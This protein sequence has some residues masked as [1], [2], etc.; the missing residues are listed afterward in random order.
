MAHISRILINNPF[1]QFNLKFARAAFAAGGLPVMKIET[2]NNKNLALLNQF[3][4]KFT[5]RFALQTEN[6]VSTN[7]YLPDN[8]ELL[9]VD[10]ATDISSLSNQ[11]NILYVVNSIDQY[12]ALKGTPIAGIIAKGNEAAG[13]VGELTSFILLQALLKETNVPVWLQGGVGIHTAPGLIGMGAHGVFLDYQCCFFPEYGLS[14]SVKDQLLKLNGT[15]T[16]IVNNTRFYEKPSLPD[17]LRKP[18]SNETTPD[19]CAESLFLAQDIANS[20]F[21]SSEYGDLETF[22]YFLNTSISG[23][24]RQAKFFNP[25]KADNQQLCKEL[26]IKY[27]IVQGPMS[28]VSDVPEFACKVANEG[29]LPFIALGTLTKEQAMPVLNETFEKIGNK[30][31][32][33][34]L[35]G[36]APREI[37]AGQTECLKQIRPKA[38]IIAGGHAWQVRELEQMGV[39]AFVHAPTEPIL[40]NFL[41]EGLKNF[42]FEGMECGGHVGPYSSMVLWERQIIRLL[43]EE[44]LEGINVLFAGGISDAR[45][46]LFI[47]LISAPLAARGANVGVIVGSAYIYTKEIVETGAINAVFQG[48][49]L[50]HTHTQVLNT[51]PGHSVRCLNTPF[52][53]YFIDTKQKLSESGLSP[54]EVGKELEKLNLGR[55]RVATKGIEKVDGKP[56]MLDEENQYNKG[57]FMM[58]QVNALFDNT[59]TIADLHRE[60][61]QGSTELLNQLPE[62]SLLFE[63]NKAVD[64]AI[65][66]MACIFPKA[67]NLEQYWLN[68]LNGTDCVVEVPDERWNKAGYFSEGKR[69]KDQ[70][71]SKWG[72]FIPEITFDPVLFGI[73]PQSVASIDPAQLLSLQVAYDALTDAGY[74]NKE[75][76]RENTA[77]IFGVDGGSELSFCYDLRAYYKKYFG[78]LPDELDKILPQFTEDSFPGILANVIPGRIANRMDFRGKN[79]S[80]DA[81]CATSLTA[82]D[83]ACREL[84]SGSANMVV[85]GAVDIHNDIADYIKFSSVQA[86]TF[87]GRCKSFDEK[88]DGISLGEGVA[89]LIL[90][91]LDDAL[92]DDDRV[93]AVIKSVGASSDGKS[94]GLTAPRKEGQIKA[95]RRAYCESGLSPAQIGM[96]EAHGTGTSVGDIIELSAITE[97]LANS[98]ALPHQAF[99]GSVKT[100]IGHTKCVAGM[101]ALI[102][103]GLSVYHAVKTP[104]INLNKPN[105]YYNENYSPFVF[106]NSIAPW[107][108]ATRIA[109]I[110]ALGFG[111]TNYHCVIQ[112]NKPKPVALT[113]S[114]FWPAELLV[115]RADTDDELKQKLDTVETLCKNTPDIRLRDIS[116]TLFSESDKPVKLSIVAT[117]VTDL[118]EKTRLANAKQADPGIYF[119]KETEGKI[120]FLF[121]GQGSQRINMARDLFAYF[122]KMAEFFNGEE[123]LLDILFPRRTFI[124][125]ELNVQAQ[126]ISNTL[127]AQPLLGIVDYSIASLLSGFGIEPDMLAG[128]SYGEIPALCF[129]GVIE[130]ADLVRIS[131]TRAM[132]IIRAVGDDC[133]AM[134][135]LNCSKEELLKLLSTEEGVYPANHNSNKQW[136]ISGYTD[137]IGK[138]ARKLDSLGISYK[139]LPVTCA[140]HSP[141]VSK[142]ADI[143]KKELD[144]FTLSPAKYTV[145]SNTTTLPYPGTPDEIKEILCRQLVSPVRFVDQ[146]K[147]MY[148]NGARIFIETGPAN[149]LGNLV[150]NII[151]KEVTVL[152]TEE[153]NRNGIEKMLDFL[154]RYISTGRTIDYKGLFNDRKAETIDLNNYLAFKPSKTSWYINGNKAV[155]LFGEL[156]AHAKKPFNKPFVTNRTIDNHA[157]TSN[158]KELRVKEY[159][160]NVNALIK[161]QHSVMMDYLGIGASSIADSALEGEFFTGMPEK[162]PET[163]EQIN[164]T[165]GFPQSNDFSDNGYT[166]VFSLLLETISE[167]TGY[168]QDMLADELN[169]E[170]DLSIDSIKRVEI[171]NTLKQKLSN[172]FSGNNKELHDKLAGS[173]TIGDMKAALEISI[174]VQERVSPVRQSSPEEEFTDIPLKDILF[175]TISAKTGYPPDMLDAE[176]DIEADLSI[177][178]IKRMEIINT[179]K[180]R[181][182]QL[183]YQLSGDFS[184]VLSRH[185]NMAGMLGWLT[186]NCFPANTTSKQEKNKVDAAVEQSQSEKV[187]RYK[188][189]LVPSHTEAILKKPLAEKSVAIIDNGTALPLQLKDELI[190]HKMN[191]DIVHSEAD[192]LTLYNGLIFLD[193]A[194]KHGNT[195]IEGLFRYI[196]KLDKNKIEW[197]YLLSD[198]KGILRQAYNQEIVDALQGFSGFLNSL[199]IEWEASCRTIHLKDAGSVKQAPEILVNEL[200]LADNASEVFYINGTRHTGK[201]TAKKWNTSNKKIA[202]DK[203]D[204]IL[205]LGG[206]QGITA[207]VV[208]NL[209]ETMPA[210]Y[211]LVGSTPFP[212][213]NDFG[214]GSIEKD[215]IRKQLIQKNLFKNP[216]ELEKSVT[217]IYKNNQIL[218]TIQAI[219]TKGSGVEYR[220]VDLSQPGSLTNLI[221]QLYTEYGRIDGVIHA[222]G[223][224]DDKF[225]H[226]KTFDSFTRVYN[227]K[228]LPLR[229]LVQNLRPDTRFCVFFSSIA[230][231]TG[232]QG[233]VDY[234]AANSVLDYAALALKHKLKGRVVSINWGPWKGKGMVS[235]S[236]EKDFRRRGIYSI[237]VNEGAGAFVNELLYGTTEQVIIMAGTNIPEGA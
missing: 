33:V 207:E 2:F 173:K 212:T 165:T 62:N 74:R 143:F 127:N 47:S 120:A 176:M 14:G 21:Y 19:N 215:E 100:Q 75:F 54:S 137:D 63:N 41:S 190:K 22:L 58:G 144:S 205:V 102:K 195:N 198:V 49:A 117:S 204:I 55:L 85:A 226:Q 3:A 152:N 57:L 8:V 193:C 223:C 48:T 68:I 112:N 222:A 200:S 86:L 4:S 20:K 140:F 71:T 160:A 129:A 147:E 163:K 166:D 16:K 136:A 189:E 164:E 234:A 79:F 184:E 168:P 59:I 32:G 201:L 133:G 174:Q 231:V 180:Q 72:G 199:N 115:F 156:P 65:I 6:L 186:E 27:P 151:D 103:A 9:I 118:G 5:G 29:A 185:K 158:E 40:D 37:W 218:E 132:S 61:S 213:K 123:E 122:P 42:V 148:N 161:A 172:G 179:L 83:L 206:A 82:I 208:K 209:S 81:A 149:V 126:N 224:L 30:P 51:L 38:A 69:A 130:K 1:N 131:K 52:A 56:T 26:G 192:N 23:H 111:G 181:L 44:T 182:V 178:S 45:S 221:E 18:S 96:Y 169:L 35:L 154:A 219:E 60:I 109:G 235:D 93:Y 12:H 10:A 167:K 110:S 99:I 50:K 77:V 141:V 175:E 233:Q 76:D 39:T 228:V 24:I 196:Q 28:R 108:A 138:F 236:L 25:M 105:K 104:T 67:R 220:S 46:A 73:P 113:I 43:K 90:K 145:W 170:A 128:H 53:H 146:V 237:P 203:N 98:G 153:K 229:E 187:F 80:V 114:E 202:F 232:S 31:W 216:K 211:I 225:F 78:E 155:P 177:D 191:V 124:E 135:A 89:V 106:N 7:F 13:K 183:Q 95:F 88:A 159:L 94:L 162:N 87:E 125:S 64:I 66:G 107:Q 101:A 70:S 217:K 227:T 171:I 150:R 157:L 230:S 84:V 188:V 194:E 116:Y 139:K 214:I 11:S 121:P 142:S 34:G 15:E 36:F 17:K 119:T 92:A 197:I 134:L 210:R 97:L 91:R